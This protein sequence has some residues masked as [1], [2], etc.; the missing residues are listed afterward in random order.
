LRLPR[1]GGRLG[2]NCIAGFEL[3]GHGR[4]QVSHAERETQDF[5]RNAAW[6]SSS[7][8]LMIGSA[9]RVLNEAGAR[10]LAPARAIPA[11]GHRG[12]AAGNVLSATTHL[13]S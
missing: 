12:A 11:A 10:R 5:S 8:A 3:F 6:D 9:E 4:I 2:I 1:P 7:A 13:R